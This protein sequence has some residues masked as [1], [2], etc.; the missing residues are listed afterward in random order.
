MLGLHRGVYAAKRERERARVLYDIGYS[1]MDRAKQYKGSPLQL[2][3][4]GGW[5]LDIGDANNAYPRNT[6][7]SKQ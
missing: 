7:L 3:S 6:I 1:E 5:C 2:F 4:V